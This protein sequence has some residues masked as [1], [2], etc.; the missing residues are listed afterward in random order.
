MT[1]EISLKMSPKIVDKAVL[2]PS[3]IA[4]EHVLNDSVYYYIDICTSVFIAA[5]LKAAGECDPPR[6]VTKDKYI[7]IMWDV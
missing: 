4:H 5:P 6:F 1:L 3:C 7:L 2:C